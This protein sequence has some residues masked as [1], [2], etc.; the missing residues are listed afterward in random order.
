MTKEDTRNT[1]TGRATPN[2]SFARFCLYFHLFFA[3]HRTFYVKQLDLQA[4]GTVAILLSYLAILILSQNLTSDRQ[5][6]QKIPLEADKCP[7]GGKSYYKSLANLI[8]KAGRRSLNVVRPLKWFINRSLMSWCTRKS[9]IIPQTD[10][11]RINQFSIKFF[12][13]YHSQNIFLSFDLSRL[14]QVWYHYNFSGKSLP[15][16]PILTDLFWNL[17]TKFSVLFSLV[18]IDALSQR[19]LKPS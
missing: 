3:Y 7:P 2:V 5:I 17:V 11:K 6:F 1:F 9:L 10:Y 19:R 12:S 15:C 8:E 13:I 14:H 4:F 16:F 18:S